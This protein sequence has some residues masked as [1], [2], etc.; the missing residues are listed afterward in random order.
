MAGLLF[1]MFRVDRIEVKGTMHGVQMQLVTR[2]LKIELGIQIQVKQ[3]RLSVTTAMVA[4]NEEQLLFI[5]GGKDSVVDEDVDEP[6]DP[7]YDE[8]DLSYDSNILF[9]VP[10]HKNYQD[11]VCEHHEVHEMHDNVQPHYVVNSHTEYEN[12]SNM[13][14]Y[15]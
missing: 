1:K 4:F 7:I 6:S 5:A 2:E 15:D 8:A 11:V 12:D 13:I 3:G 9:E 10:D 14:P